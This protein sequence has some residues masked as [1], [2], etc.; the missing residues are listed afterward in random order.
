MFSLVVMATRPNTGS[1]MTE[2]V[3]DHFTLLH[4]ARAIQARHEILETGGTVVEADTAFEA[5]FLMPRKPEYTVPALEQYPDLNG[6]LIAFLELDM[7]ARPLKKVPQELAEKL[8]AAWENFEFMRLSLI[9][10]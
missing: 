5:I 6:L 2:F 8:F 3:V 1:M 7:E 4:L 9:H 10:I